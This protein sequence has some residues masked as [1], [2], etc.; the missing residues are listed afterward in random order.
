MELI[1][2]QTIDFFK[3]IQTVNLIFMI[4]V[5]FKKRKE[6]KRNSWSINKDVF[7]RRFLNFPF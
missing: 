4:N 3:G 7:L 1:F 5:S 6:K 2:I